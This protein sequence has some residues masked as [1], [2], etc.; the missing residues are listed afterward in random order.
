[1][2]GEAALPWGAG[3]PAGTWTSVGVVAIG[4]APPPGGWPSAGASPSPAT[5]KGDTAA[6]G[7]GRSRAQVS[8]C[9]LEDGERACSRRTRAAQSEF[10]DPRGVDRLKEAEAARRMMHAV[11][12]T[13][14]GGGQETSMKQ[15]STI[16]DGELRRLDLFRLISI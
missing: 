11:R 6:S 12:G 10:K 3:A 8:L 13:E 15:Q 4:P 1:M 16:K 2:P 9:H 7:D 5:E 14:A